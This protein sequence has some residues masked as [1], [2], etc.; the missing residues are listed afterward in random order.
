MPCHEPNEPDE[1]TPAPSAEEV[2]TRLRATVGA[3]VRATRSADDLAP[4]PAAVLDLIDLRGPMTT[5]GLAA[6]R[7]VRHQTMAV[8]VKDLVDAG[9]LV[10]APD[11]GD[12]RKKLLALTPPGRAALDADRQRRVSL[13]AQALRTTLTGDE[14]RAVVHALTLIDRITV[15]LSGSQAASAPGRGPITGP[16]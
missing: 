3:L 6:G 14:K 10:A 13:L 7:G 12:G 2:A 8:T 11:P 9:L 4:I 16:W 5:A 1:P 15:G